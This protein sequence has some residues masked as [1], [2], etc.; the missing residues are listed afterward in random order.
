MI[1]LGLGL[2]ANVSLDVQEVKTFGLVLVQVHLGILALAQ[3]L[4]HVSLELLLGHLDGGELLLLGHGL[5]LGVDAHE[6]QVDVLE[7]EE[8]LVVLHGVSPFEW[9]W[10]DV[11][12]ALGP[13][14]LAF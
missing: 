4:G 2:G 9:W 11:P 14:V 6:F 13:L 5:E 3:D 10:K 8:G 12:E 7:L 1:V